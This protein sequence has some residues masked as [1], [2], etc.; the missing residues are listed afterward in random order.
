MCIRDRLRACLP[1]Q[2]DRAVH[3]PAT[4][5][6]KRDGVHA[7]IVRL[8]E[9]DRGLVRSVELSARCLNTTPAAAS[10]R[11]RVL[12]KPRDAL[13]T[14][15]RLTDRLPIAIDA[16]GQP[17]YARALPDKGAVRLQDTRGVAVKR[18]IAVERR[19]KTGDISNARGERSIGEQVEAAVR[20]LREYL[21]VIRKGADEPAQRDY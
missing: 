21:P 1:S 6:G 12:S 9:I 18:D 17:Q 5:G 14:L 8:C 7:F 16:S 13:N 20:T 3:H 4:I 2:C 10:E 11:Q 15:N 19:I